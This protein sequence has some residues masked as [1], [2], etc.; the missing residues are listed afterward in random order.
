[1]GDTELDLSFP[2]I[3]LLV[4]H[5]Q[6]DAGKTHIHAKG[7]EKVRRKKETNEMLR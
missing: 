3:D 7:R 5:Y 4:E 6:E 1:M 2:R